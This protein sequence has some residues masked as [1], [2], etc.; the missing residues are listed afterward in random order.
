MSSP[1]A[2]L[3]YRNYDGPIEAPSFRWWVIAKMGMR[4]GIKK[5]AFWFF[6]SL[7]SYFYLIL[8]TAFYFI[9]LISQ[10]G[11]PKLLAGITWKDQFLNCLNIA[12]LPLFILA[13]LIGTSSIASDNRANALLVY[14]SK[15]VSKLDYL[16]GKW[17]SIFLPLYAATAIPAIVFYGYCLLSFR[18]YGFASQ[19]PWL[20]AKLML[21]LPTTAA[22]HAS[23]SVGVSSLF[24]QPRLAG[25]AYAAIYFIS[26]MFT[27]FV[28]VI[29]ITNEARGGALGESSP[30]RTLFYGSVDGLQ[31]G[32]SKAVFDSAGSPAFPGSNSG[33]QIPAPN[34]YL[35]FA[36]I[37][38]ICAISVATAYSRI[39][40]VEV[41]KG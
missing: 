5:R 18:S 32:L 27:Q 13:M 36:I 34:G 15:P 4:L 6:A 24:D 30:L 7:S 26:N 35:M 19:D 20:F 31:S 9:D 23:L 11:A 29:L 1:I 2:D 22:I 40:A 3:S 14:L 39:R 16:I 12:Q 10:S 33:P 37:A 21:I 28:K 38:A 8:A 25:A 17:V 41:V